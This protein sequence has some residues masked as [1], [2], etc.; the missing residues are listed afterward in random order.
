MHLLGTQFLEDAVTY[1]PSE[2][3]TAVIFSGK[4]K[5]K[6]GMLSCRHVDVE[7][8]SYI[9]IYPSR[10]IGYHC[11]NFTLTDRR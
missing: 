1:R 8:I 3:G 6:G 11:M 7:W 10:S 2:V 5:H 9:S 4:N